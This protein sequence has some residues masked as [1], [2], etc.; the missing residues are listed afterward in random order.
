MM[1]AA[2]FLAARVGSTVVDGV[3]AILTLARLKRRGA[4]P[5]AADLLGAS[6]AAAAMFA[7]KLPLFVALGLGRFTKAAKHRAYG[8]SARLKCRFWWLG[9][10]R[11]VARTSDRL[12]V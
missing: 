12:N 7:V 11:D 8:S 5:L 2:L 1:S 10:I 6:A 3:V 9:A 4:R